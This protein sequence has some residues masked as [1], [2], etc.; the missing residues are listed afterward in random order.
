MLY[1]L[2]YEGGCRRASR[3]RATSVVE[4]LASARAASRCRLRETGGD[5]SRSGGGGGRPQ[6][7]RRR[8]GAG[9]SGLA[10]PGGRSR[11]RARRRGPDR[12]A[13]PPRLRA[14]R[15]LRG[16]PDGDRVTGA[17]RSQGRLG[18]ARPTDG[19]STRRRPR[20]AARAECRCDRGGPR[21]GRS[22]VPLAHAPDRRRCTLDHQRIALTAWCADSLP[23]AHRLRTARDP[24]RNILGPGQVRDRRGPGNARGTGGAFHPPAR[25]AADERR[26]PAPRAVG[27]RRRLADRP[28]R[29]ASNCGR[30]R[31]RARERVRRDRHRD[32]GA[33]T[34]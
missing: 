27:A 4:R 33:V 6:R 30:A 17:E 25:Q 26:R 7:A 23:C 15:L 31:G 22:G 32:A 8:R 18:P 29:F 10:G 28:G 9:P 2:S 3:R 16:A 20:R 24:I 5:A 12:G 13:H 14:R 1:P 34:R 19:A 11:R 21:T